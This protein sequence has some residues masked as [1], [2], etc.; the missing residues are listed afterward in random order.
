MQEAIGAKHVIS[1]C[2]SFDSSRSM[3]GLERLLENAE[4]IKG[5]I[6]LSGAQLCLLD[7]YCYLYAL[8]VGLAMSV[9]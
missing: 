8:R 5:M 4:S 6:N 2:S 9:A 1:V 7:L 3:Q